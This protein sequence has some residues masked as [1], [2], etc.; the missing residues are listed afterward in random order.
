MYLHYFEEWTLPEERGSIPYFDT[1]NGYLTFITEKYPDNTAL[2]DSTRSVTYAGMGENIARKRGFLKQQ[3]LSGGGN[4]G[5]FDVNSIDEVEWFL[6]ATTAGFTAVMLPAQLSAEVLAGAS[7]LYELKALFVGE[8]LMAKTAGV[9]VPV[10]PMNSEADAAP[11]AQVE[12]KTPAAIFFTGGTTGQPKGVVLNHGAMVR[13][14]HNGTYRDRQSMFGQTEVCALPLTHVFGMVF[15]TLSPLYAGGH[16]AMCA[17]MRDLFKEMMRVHPNTMVAVPGMA[18]IMLG[19]ARTRGFGALGGKLKLVICG[20]APVPPRLR[21]GFKEFGVSVLAGYGMTETANLVSGNFEM[22]RDPYSVGHQYPEQEI[23]IVDGELQVKGDMLFDGYWKNPEATKA[24]FTEDGWLRTGDLGEVDDEGFIRIV[25]RIKNLII[26]AN[27]ENV[28]PEE[29]E[30]NYYRSGM[31]KDCLVYEEEIAGTPSIV[32]EIQPMEG[33]TDEALLAEANRIAATL[34][35]Y[36]RPA[37]TVIRHQ[38]F[39]KSP[40]MKIVRGQ[41]GGKS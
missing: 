27:G 39:V 21:E 17:Q 16:V 28:S 34:P 9:K 5:L 40:S 7:M 25:G 41:Q 4:I 14:P 35:T 1:L 18:E 15:S 2:S 30:D 3:G 29:V 26:L 23:R 6:A 37:K 12:K 22:D 10:Y 32:I 31:V 13:G 33:V 11:M 38:D 8:A 24:A 19:V 36:M 20:A